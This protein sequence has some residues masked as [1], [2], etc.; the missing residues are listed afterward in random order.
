MTYYRVSKCRGFEQPALNHDLTKCNCNEL[1]NESIVEGVPWLINSESTKPFP[2]RSFRTA[3]N[4]TPLER[5]QVQKPQSSL[6][7]PLLSRLTYTAEE[8]LVAGSHL[9]QESS[10]GFW[11]LGQ[12][13]FVTRNWMQMEFGIFRRRL[14]DGESFVLRPYSPSS[15][16]VYFP[17]RIGNGTICGF[18]RTTPV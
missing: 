10:I 9:L 18:I 5:R 16:I 14:K 12:N 15:H 6:R 8:A 3:R 4:L 7:K 17:R 11:D 13:D 2:V 1:R